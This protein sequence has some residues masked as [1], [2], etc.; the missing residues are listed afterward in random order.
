MLDETL[1]RAEQAGAPGMVSRMLDDPNEAVKAQQNLQR[2]QASG[3]LGVRS[4]YE[5]YLRVLAETRLRGLMQYARSVGYRGLPA[6]AGGAA[7]GGGL[8]GGD[9]SRGPGT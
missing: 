5:R 4:D 3:Q 6:A 8:L 7:L 2:L 9:D 1:Q